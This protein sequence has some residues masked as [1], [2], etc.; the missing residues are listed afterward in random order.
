[1]K[2]NDIP[3]YFLYIVGITHK[4]HLRGSR[5][6]GQTELPPGICDAPYGIMYV[7]PADFVYK[8]TGT[9][10]PHPEAIRRSIELY[11]FGRTS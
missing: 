8:T 1:M 4:P 6:V 2:D 11:Y 7:V 3:N 9:Y 5:G 10:Y